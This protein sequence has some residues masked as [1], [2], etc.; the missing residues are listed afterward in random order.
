MSATEELLQDHVFIRRLQLVIEK[1]YTLLYEGKDVP[2][3]DLV[4]IADMIEQFVD[5]FHHGKEEK[6]YFPETENKDRYS[7]EIRKFVIEHELGRRIANRV[8]IHLEEFLQGK[9]AR[10][11][12][13]RYLKAYSVFILDHTSKEDRFF[14][15]V[16]EK[17][18][19]SEKEEKDLK[20]EFERMRHECMSKS[21]NL[22]EVLKQLEN[23]EW[24]R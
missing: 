20:K 3:G 12:L 11:P 8:R 13:A 22:V 5:N 23:A 2:F 18:S 9:D 6:S 7:E 24:M 15:D 21:G 14:N 19:L 10:E 1:C 17:R 16:R 4:K